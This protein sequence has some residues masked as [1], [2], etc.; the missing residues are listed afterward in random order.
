M[1][2]QCFPSLYRA[3][4]T[5]TLCARESQREFIFRVCRNILHRCQRPSTADSSCCRR[6][7]EIVSNDVR[8]HFASESLEKDICCS[9][10]FI[11]RDIPVT[12]FSAT[13]RAR[14]LSTQRGKYNSLIKVY[15]RQTLLRCDG[16]F[17]QRFFFHPLFV[18]RDLRTMPQ[19]VIS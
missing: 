5:R 12:V 4:F 14:C 7:H 6:T 17:H 10:K 3:F 8:C 2:E 19:R 1:R 18:R 16:I 9:A 11:I 13:F 15:S